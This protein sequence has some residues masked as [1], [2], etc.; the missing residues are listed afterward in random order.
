MEITTL[1]SAVSSITTVVSL[2]HQ[3]S[4][5]KYQTKPKL[6]SSEREVL[7]RFPEVNQL[8]L[9]LTKFCNIVTM[10]ASKVHLLSNKITELISARD[11]MFKGSD[12]EARDRQW[13][14]MEVELNYLGAC[15][16]E[17]TTYIKAN[18]PLSTSN[19]LTKI[20]TYADVL[21]DKF[22]MAKAFQLARDIDQVKNTYS[23]ISGLA[24]EIK[25]NCLMLLHYILNAYIWSGKEG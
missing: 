22:N 16:S 4:A 9:M 8:A 12:Q 15:I 6:N 2:V 10:E 24:N 21:N 14:N 23:D 18:S 25:G 7:N 20:T 13:Q 1:A 19:R 5:G 11:A 17:L 3:I